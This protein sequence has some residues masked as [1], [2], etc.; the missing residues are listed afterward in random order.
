MVIGLLGSRRPYAVPSQSK[1]R[2]SLTIDLVMVK[3]MLLHE[4]DVRRL[5]TSPRKGTPGAS[6]VGR[7]KSS[8][9]RGEF[10][11]FVTRGGP[12]G[13]LGRLWPGVTWDLGSGLYS[14]F[15]RRGQG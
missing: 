12:G 5:G 3:F 2:L 4:E 10:A 1:T 8:A 15:H 11:N 9:P 6:D 7:G 14:Y 13:L